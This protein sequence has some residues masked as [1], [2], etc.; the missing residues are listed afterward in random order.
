MEKHPMANICRFV[1][2]PDRNIHQGALLTITDTE[3]ILEIPRYPGLPKSM[4]HVLEEAMPKIWMT[5][6]DKKLPTP[7]SSQITIGS[8]SACL[9]DENQICYEID[10]TGYHLCTHTL[11]APKAAS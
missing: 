4:M 3:A 10:F 1:E 7:C 6:Q 11:L 9:Y 2:N 8:Y 5:V